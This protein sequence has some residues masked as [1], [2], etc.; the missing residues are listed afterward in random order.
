MY[1]NGT[2][3]ATGFE[4]NSPRL[5]QLAREM[6]QGFAHTQN[7]VTFESVD[8][9]YEHFDEDTLFLV[10]DGIINICSNENT[11]FSCEEGD[12]IG[13]SQSFHLPSPTL[14]TDAMSNYNPSIAMIFCFIS[15]TISAASAAGAITWSPQFATD[16]TPRRS[17]EKSN[18]RPDS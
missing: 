2:E 3:P 14:M 1:Q 13:I 17:V 9:L 5:Q 18:L 8:D 12:L 7:T 15:T 16:R 4:A 6:L 10:K 11:L